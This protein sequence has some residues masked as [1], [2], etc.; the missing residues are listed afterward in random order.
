MENKQNNGEIGPDY[1]DPSLLSSYDESPVSQTA[2]VGNSDSAESVLN[3]IFQ[4][5]ID[6]E[7]SDNA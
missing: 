2:P 6:R 4:Q 5:A 3:S 1:V 7:A